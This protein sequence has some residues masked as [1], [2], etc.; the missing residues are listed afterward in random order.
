MRL[1]SVIAR[2]NGSG[3]SLN[4]SSGSL[5]RQP[6]RMGAPA[7]LAVIEQ[8]ELP[9]LLVGVEPPLPETDHLAGSSHAGQVFAAAVTARDE[10]T[11]ELRKLHTAED[12]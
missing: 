3:R 1:M 6:P 12:G 9:P 2:C 11:K 4:W 8:R 5:R 10:I 7:G